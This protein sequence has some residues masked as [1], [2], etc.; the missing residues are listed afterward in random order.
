MRTTVT[1]DPDVEAKLRAA[2]RERGVPFKVALNDAVKTDPKFA[3]GFASLGE[4]YRLKYILDHSP[5]VTLDLTLARG[6]NYYTGAIFEVKVAPIL[7]I[8]M[9]SIGG[10]G[11]YEIEQP[12]C[13]ALWPVRCRCRCG[14]PP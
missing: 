5:A 8:A 6:L 2:M 4:A 12:L 1:L 10:G 3:L 11:R 9:G 14:R 13:R 7:D